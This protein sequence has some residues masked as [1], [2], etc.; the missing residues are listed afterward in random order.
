MASNTSWL[1]SS[2]STS[3]CDD[4]HL[5]K[6]IA[7]HQRHIEILISKSD[8]GAGKKGASLGPDA[9]KVS[10]DE[11][12]FPLFHIFPVTEY[13]SKKL[14]SPLLFESP[15]K[16]IQD[17]LQRD[18]ELCKLMSR[19]LLEKRTFLIF[20]GDHSN[21][22]GFI[23]GIREAFPSQ[24]LGVIWIDA[25]GDIHT[26]FTSPSG[27]LHGMPL[28]ALLGLDN[29]EN[30]I[31]NSSSDIIEN[32]NKLKKV[33]RRN[34]CPKLQ[35]DELVLLE[36]RELEEQ[37]WNAIHQLKIKYF[38]PKNRKQRGIDFIIQQTLHHLRDCDLIFVTFDV[39]SLNASVSEGT[40]TPSADGLS[41]EEAK[42][43]LKALWHL[44]NLCGLEVTEINPLLDYKNTMAKTIIEVI[45]YIMTSS[46]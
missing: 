3:F 37:E 38:I 21:V 31:R 15:A 28:G 29:Q 39:D 43:L 16:Y 23:S 26:P 44:P 12:N 30:K 40:G 46:G 33:G 27:N 45:K 32:W 24:K 14:C 2:S 6:A 18:E 1:R 4:F 10:A 36:I 19:A 17:I 5:H 25:H 7:S 35:P 9:L 42:N 13:E 20:S 11:H 41:V 34:I 8:L 22:N